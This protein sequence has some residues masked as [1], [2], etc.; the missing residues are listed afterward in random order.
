MKNPWFHL[1]EMKPE[2]RLT[3]S[4]VRN[5]FRWLA[6]I[7]VVGFLLSKP[8]GMKLEFTDYIIHNMIYIDIGMVGREYWEIEFPYRW[9]L[10]GIVFLWTLAAIQPTR[11]D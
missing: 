1:Q 8:R 4:Q 6:C 5:F 9:L 10:A 11:D 2:P 7:A 3:K